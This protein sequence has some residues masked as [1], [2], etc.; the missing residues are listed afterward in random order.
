VYKFPN[1]IQR[2]ALSLIEACED[3]V[4]NLI[5][6]S[7]ETFGPGTW[8]AHRLRDFATTCLLLPQRTGKTVLTSMVASDD[9]VVVFASEGMLKHF[10]QNTLD[11]VPCTKVVGFNSMPSLKGLKRLWVHEPFW[12]RVV[13]DKDTMLMYNWISRAASWNYISIILIDSPF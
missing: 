8:N 2:S 12:S 9:D 10:S 6:Q 3:N 1:R 4:A 7:P 13:Q 5:K 11:S